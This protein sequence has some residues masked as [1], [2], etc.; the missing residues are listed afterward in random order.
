MIIQGYM[1]TNAKFQNTLDYHVIRPKSICSSLLVGNT[2]PN[3]HTTKNSL[4]ASH[5]V[6][7]SLLMYLGRSVISHPHNLRMWRA[8]L[9]IQATDS[10]VQ[11]DEKNGS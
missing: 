6:N 2:K 9:S 3:N 5:M 10:C 8:G 7:W 1:W 4:A 11:G